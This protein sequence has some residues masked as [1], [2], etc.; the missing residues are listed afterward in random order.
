MN[1]SP[2]WLTATAAW[3]ATQETSGAREVGRP[4]GALR[5]TIRPPDI[6]RVESFVEEKSI[7]LTGGPLLEVPEEAAAQ[8]RAAAEAR[9]RELE[10]ELAKR[11]GSG[12]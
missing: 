11:T 12:G 3:A 6:A 2:Q 7:V 4:T 5:A 1:F 8:G 10:A 9:V